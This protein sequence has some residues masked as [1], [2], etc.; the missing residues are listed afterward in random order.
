MHNPEMAEQ[1]RLIFEIKNNDP[2][3]LLDLTTSLVAFGREYVDYAE[4]TLDGKYRTETRLYVKEIRSGSI[5]ADLVP[6]A[7][8]L[9]PIISDVNTVVGFATRLQALVKWLVSPTKAEKPS[10]VTVSQLQNIKSI[11][12]PVAK[13][14]ASQMN[15]HTEV[16]NHAPVYI[17]LNSSQANEL[18]NRADREIGL[19]QTP[20]V[21]AHKDVVMYL[22][23]ARNDTVSNAGDRAIIESISRRPTKVIFATEKL[24]LEVLGVKDNLFRHAF[25]VDVTVETVE[26]RPILYK[27]T[28]VSETLSIDQADID[29]NG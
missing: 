25:I 26:G 23:Q 28:N 17:N 2:V 7:P 5:I 3:E 13:D 21:G 11:V 9:L 24:K 1:G 10:G 12:E 14:S 22:W 29:N 19:I 27:V 4:E 18:Q 8:A 6:Y 15:I 16:H 20:V